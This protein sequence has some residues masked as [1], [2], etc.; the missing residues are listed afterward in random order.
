MT[1]AGG[2][3][4]RARRSHS[5]SNRVFPTP[6][7]P[8]KKAI[9]GR[10][11]EASAKTASSSASSASRPTTCALVTRVVTLEVSRCGLG[12]AGCDEVVHEVGVHG[13]V[14]S[15]IGMRAILD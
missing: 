5:L 10:P 11:A 3:P 8:A 4:A 13:A 7:S 14:L 12:A 1:R 6:D 9:V 2:S 15:G